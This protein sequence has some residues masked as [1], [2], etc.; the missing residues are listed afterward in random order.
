MAEK[1]VRSRKFR[2]L[3][4]PDNP[5]HVA[6]IDLLKS[7]PKFA[8]ILH[9]KDKLEDGTPKKLHWHVSVWFNNAKWSAALAKEL[10]IEHRFIQPSNN[11]THDL[12]YLVHADDPDKYQY[13][14][15]EIVTNMSVDIEKALLDIAEEDKVL[16]ILDLID[17]FE[18]P[19]STSQFVRLICK[20]GLYADFRRSSYVFLQ[21]LQEHNNKFDYDKVAAAWAS[22]ATGRK[23]GGV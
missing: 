11:S 5:A 18:T 22:Q 13:D 3:L 7:Y 16:K 19:L 21:I 15:D 1:N 10:G 4:Y 17:D 9:D 6:A 8:I 20:A 2:L 14:K 12:R 23:H